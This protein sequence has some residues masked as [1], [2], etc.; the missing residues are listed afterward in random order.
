MRAGRRDLDGTEIDRPVGAR[1][2]LHTGVDPLVAHDLVD[3]VAKL[4]AAQVG[5][6][7]LGRL[8][9]LIA[10]RHEV[11]GIGG[12]RVGEGRARHA[13]FSLD[14]RRGEAALAV[15]AHVDHDVLWI[16]V[17]GDAVDLLAAVD[18]AHLEAEILLE[19]AVA[20][21]VEHVIGIE[22]DARARSAHRLAGSRRGR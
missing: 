8:G 18:L 1:D 3:L 15:I 6:G 12:V 20:L 19:Q 4:R 22:G 9:G 16:A 14:H 17:V 2:A 11:G 5:F 7:A 13:P 10:L 21:A